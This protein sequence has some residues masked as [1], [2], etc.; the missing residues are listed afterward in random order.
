MEKTKVWNVENISFQY[1]VKSLFCQSIFPVEQLQ[2]LLRWNWHQFAPVGKKY[3]CFAQTNIQTRKKQRKLKICTVGPRTFSVPVVV[4][5]REVEKIDKAE[6]ILTNLFQLRKVCLI[7][8]QEKEYLINM[9]NH[10]NKKSANCFHSNAL[11]WSNMFIIWD[12]STS[13]KLSLS[14]GILSRWNDWYI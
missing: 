1:S 3:L 6:T 8:Q 11:S 9:K 5:V 2:H 7:Y 12:V 13:C 14:N 10:Q 4:K